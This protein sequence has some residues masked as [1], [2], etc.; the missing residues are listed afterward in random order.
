MAPEFVF[1]MASMAP[2]G[3]VDT[4]WKTNSVWILPPLLP[5]LG[6]EHNP[7]PKILRGTPASL[8]FHFGVLVSRMSSLCL[9][10]ALSLVCNMHLCTDVLSSVLYRKFDKCCLL[11][12]LTIFFLNWQKLLKNWQKLWKNWQTLWKT[13]QKLWKN[14]QF[15]LEKWVSAEFLYLKVPV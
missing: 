14:W 12:K 10:S 3:A 7:H 1:Q 9:S 15:W 5:A 4:K 8:N 6:R 2:N 11:K 13:W